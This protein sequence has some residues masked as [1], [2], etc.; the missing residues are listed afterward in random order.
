MSAPPADK[1]HALL[2]RHRAI[3]AGYA[4]NH[5]AKVPVLRNRVSQTKAD[6]GTEAK[7]LQQIADTQ[8]KATANDNHVAEI[9]A[10]LGKPKP[11]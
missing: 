4:A 11:S 5:R 2:V 6:S 1:M 3:F 8:A 9:D 10:L 7:L